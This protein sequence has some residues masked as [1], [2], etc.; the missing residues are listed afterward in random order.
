[1]DFNI[2]DRPLHK[3]A[4]LR[5]S[6]NGHTICNTMR[7][8]PFLSQLRAIL[9]PGWDVEAPAAVALNG[10][11]RADASLRLAGPDGS[12]AVLLIEM[13]PRLSARQAADL[14]ARFGRDAPVE[15]GPSRIVFTRFASRMAR[16]RLRTGRISYLDLSG[17]AWISIARPAVF[18]ERQ[19]ADRDP[20]PL[21]R[22][23]RSLKG[24]TAARIV[25]A[26]CDWRPPVGVRELARRAGADPGYVARV[27]SLLVD[28]DLIV[29]DRTGEV[30]E[31]RWKELLRRW[32]ADYT[33]SGTNRALACLAPRGI[34]D[35]LRRLTTLGE[36]Y[37]LTGSFGVPPEALIAPGGVLSCYVRSAELAAEKL[38]LRPTDSGANVFLL[39]PF[40]DVVFARTPFRDGRPVVAPTQ[41]VVDLLSGTGREPAQ[42]D[43]LLTWMEEH[44]D[45]WRA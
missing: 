42:A 41:C 10:P 9:P 16:E 40:D 39:E 11:P 37:A 15:G 18:I 25:R 6:R 30:L 23:V 31:V 33:L 26:L 36:T 29:R 1:M 45:E 5:M 24:A 21:R 44:V 35:V 2:Q 22:G 38:D 8:E 13:K 28:E 3:Y 20:T 7:P 14:S 12:T 32:S 43:A 17:N 27:L 4:M 34:G 19:G